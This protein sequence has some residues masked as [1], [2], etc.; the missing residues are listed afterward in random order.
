MPKGSKGYE[1]QPDGGY[2]KYDPA[3]ATVIKNGGNDAIHVGVVSTGTKYPDP[4][5][6][7]NGKPE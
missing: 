1:E 6:K 5:A 2:S 3:G 7:G 4:L